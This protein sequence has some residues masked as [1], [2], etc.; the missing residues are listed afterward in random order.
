M[1]RRLAGRILLAGL[2]VFP[3]AV[4]ADGLLHSTRPVPAPP[5]DSIRFNPYFGFYPT[6]W[7]PFPGAPAALFESAPTIALPPEKLVPI[8]P[9]EVRPTIK[10]PTPEVP[11]VPAKVSGTQFGE[12]ASE[13]DVPREPSK[14]VPQTLPKPV[15][16]RPAPIVKEPLAVR[17]PG[18]RPEPAVESA[19]L[20][21][22]KPVTITPGSRLE[23]T[24]ANAP[25]IAPPPAE[26]IRKTIEPARALAGLGKPISPPREPGPLPPVVDDE[27]VRPAWPVIANGPRP[28]GK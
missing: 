9:S 16:I 1:T 7:R 28:P 26:P 17:P 2:G 25:P 11:K 10:P 6:Q 22:P 5:S 14:L 8:A 15:T 21:Q 24:S 18:P 27:T 13:P 4:H 20:P 12:L 23:A 3:T 19:T